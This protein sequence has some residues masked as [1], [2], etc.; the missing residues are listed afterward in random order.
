MTDWTNADY[1]DGKA[2]AKWFKDNGLLRGEIDSPLYTQVK[3]W[4]AG[5]RAE[6][7]VL[8]RWLIYK[9]CY[10]WELPDEVWRVSLHAKVTS[11]LDRGLPIRQIARELGCAP[12]TVRYHRDRGV[13]A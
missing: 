4:R 8:D 6:L 12:A 10:L 5:D 3:N 13:A 11:L 9:G 7:D 1:A 2:V